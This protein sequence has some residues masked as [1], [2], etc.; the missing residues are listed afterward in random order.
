MTEAQRNASEA[1]FV[2][3]FEQK[4]NNNSRVDSDAGI[5]RSGNGKPGERTAAVML[6]GTSLSG[7]G[8]INKAPADWV[9]CDLNG[10]G[11]AVFTKDQVKYIAVNCPY[12]L[13]DVLWTGVNLGLLEYRV[14]KITVRRAADIGE[15]D[16]GNPWI[17][18]MEFEEEKM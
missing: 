10:A 11:Q 2:A 3:A 18:V 9:F 5:R 4:A 6:R 8:R 7:L 15:K 17:W 14:N 1:G 13:G 16:E 12:Q